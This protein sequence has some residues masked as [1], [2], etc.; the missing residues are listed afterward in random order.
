MRNLCS[1][2]VVLILAACDKPAPAGSAAVQSAEAH[3]TALGFPDHFDGAWVMSA[4]WAGAM[5][6]ALALEG[7][8]YFYWRYSDV[9]REEPNYPLTGKFRVEGDQ[10][11]LYAPSELA[12]G[13]PVDPKEIHSDQ[14]QIV[15]RD[16]STILHPAGES[17]AGDRLLIADVQFNPTMPFRNQPNLKP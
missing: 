7:N 9:L 3:Q 17:V 11:I 1:V 14:W 8:R 4:N 6:V 12:T 16:F 2:V 15:H 13:K 10:L 5:G